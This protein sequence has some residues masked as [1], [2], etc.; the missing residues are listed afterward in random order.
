MEQ[1]LRIE[2]ILSDYKGRGAEF[3][4]TVDMLCNKG[5]PNGC[6]QDYKMLM[7]VLEILSL[8]EVIVGK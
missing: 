6:F 3:K 8:C 5:I 1:L 2:E 4:A 7:D